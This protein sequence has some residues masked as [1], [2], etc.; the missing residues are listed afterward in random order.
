MEEDSTT[1]AAETKEDTTV[2]TF[3]TDAT[4]KNKEHMKDAFRVLERRLEKTLASLSDCE[5]ADLEEFVEEM[6]QMSATK[7]YILP[8]SAHYIVRSVKDSLLLSFVREYV[9][10][11]Y[12]ASKCGDSDDT[13]DDS[14][15]DDSD[16]DDREGNV[17]SVHNSEKDCSSGD[18]D[19]EDFPDADDAGDSVSQTIHLEEDRPDDDNHYYYVDDISSQVIQATPLQ[20][21]RPQQTVS[22]ALGAAIPLY[23]EW[24]IHSDDSSLANE[25]FTCTRL[26]EKNLITV[27][28]SHLYLLKTHDHEIRSTRSAGIP[29]IHPCRFWRS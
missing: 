13:D 14:D 27:D 6:N 21:E 15:G 28:Y 11:L 23:V 4:K 16:G 20:A 17:D 3:T 8:D 5:R 7:N 22:S 26:A 18:V 25:F 19:V 2:L 29:K 24:D 9:P 1:I 12:A 10:K